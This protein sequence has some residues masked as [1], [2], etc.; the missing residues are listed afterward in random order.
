MT[1]K[2]N[3]CNFQVYSCRQEEVTGCRGCFGAGCAQ[4]LCGTAQWPR[5][6][7]GCGYWHLC[8]DLCRASVGFAAENIPDQ[9]G[10]SASAI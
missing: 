6:A 7:S 2:N 5:P 4:V 9:A 1:I 8:L 3:H 10:L